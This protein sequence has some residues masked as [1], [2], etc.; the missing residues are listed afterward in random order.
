MVVTVT[1]IMYVDHKWQ[2]IDEEVWQWECQ[3]CGD[4]S[5]Y[6]KILRKWMYDPEC[7]TREL[8]VVLEDN[9]RE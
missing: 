5:R 3:K 2:Q 1:P 4:K 9:W 8:C 6:S 7:E